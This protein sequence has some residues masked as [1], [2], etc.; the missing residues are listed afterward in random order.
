VLTLSVAAADT[1][2]RANPEPTFGSKIEPFFNYIVH[3]YITKYDYI[4]IGLMS[5]T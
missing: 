1:M 3:S 4:F 2:F 5:L